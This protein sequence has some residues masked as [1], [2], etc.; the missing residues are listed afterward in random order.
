[1]SQRFRSAASRSLQSM[2]DRDRDLD[3]TVLVGNIHSC[4]TEEILFELFLQAGPVDEV[5]IFRDGAQASY[6]CVY[7]KHAEAVPYAVELL[8]GIWLYGQPIKLQRKTDGHYHRNEACAYYTGTG[9]IADSA[10]AVRRDDVVLSLNGSPVEIPSNEAYS[11]SDMVYGRRLQVC[12]PAVWL[13]P[14]L[15]LCP[16]SAHSSGTSLHRSASSGVG[17]ASRPL[18]GGCCSSILT[19]YAPVSAFISSDSHCPL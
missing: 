19:P 16:S 4:V 12:P 3:K 14:P 15:Q 17:C 10:D 8:N 1:M 7:Y 6:G 5:R 2:F 9:L 18:Y 11:W 13:C